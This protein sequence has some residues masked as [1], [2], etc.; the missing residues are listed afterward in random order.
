MKTVRLLLMLFPGMLLAQIQI[1]VIEV[2]EIV[3]AI[4][5][6]SEPEIEGHGEAVSSTQRKTDSLYFLNGDRLAGELK[7]IEKD[8]GLVWKHPDA[9]QNLTYTLK[10]LKKIQLK[11][12]VEEVEDL[13]RL[14]RIQLTNGDRYRGR[15]VSMNLEDFVIDSPMSGKITLRSDMIDSVRPMAQ[16]TA[17]YE[18]PNSLEE[19]EQNQSGNQGWEFKNDA[20]Y[21][22]SHNE[23]VG[24][25]LEDHPD[26]MSLECHI[27]WKGN[28]NLQIGFWGRDPKNVNQNCFTLSI[29]NNYLRGYR[30]YSKIGRNELG[31]A[32]IRDEMND[33]EVR[34]KLLLNREKKEVLVLIDG[35]MIARWKDTFDGEIKG[36][37]ILFGGMGNNPVKVSDISIREWDGEFDLDEGD[38]PKVLDQLITTNGDSFAGALEKIESDTLFFKNDFA[39]FQVPMDRVSEVMMSES[40]RS[41]PRLQKGDVEIF[42]PNG[43]H[44]TL[45][46]I[47]LDEKVFV[48]SSESTGE[49]KL[50]KTFFDEMKLNPYD[51]RHNFE[52]DSW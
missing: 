11:T 31:N 43:E 41:M 19:W 47:R 27:E 25:E 23:I 48:G 9:N 3:E 42:F 24:M 26:K 34:L 12:P 35:N 2:D 40:T 16:S 21:S 4:P 6:G 17:I 46:L 13:T 5:E 33:G 1:E 44:I 28:M 15:I 10:N 14:P 52:E 29:Q 20:I 45:D 51:E 39:T 18:G 36:D 30:N 32:Q 38:D 22:N 49:V 37:V 50:S 8:K 7:G